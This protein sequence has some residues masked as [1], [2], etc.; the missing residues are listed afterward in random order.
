M[1]YKEFVRGIEIYNEKEWAVISKFIRSTEKES[2]K[3]WQR[4][5]EFTRGGEGYPADMQKIE[6]LEIGIPLNTFDLGYG[7]TLE[8]I[9]DSTADELKET[10]AEALRADQRLLMKVF[11]SKCLVPG[12]SGASRGFWDSFETKA[13]PPYRGN[14]FLTSHDHYN[15]S[16]AATVSLADLTALKKHIREHGYMGDLYLFINSGTVKAF[17][18]LAGWTTAM[19]ATSIIE[20]VATLGLRAVTKFNE[21]IVVIED[22][23]PDGY[24]FG[25]EGQILPVSMREPINPQ[26]RGLK[27]YSGPHTEYPLVEA[28]YRRRCGMDVVHRG[29][30]AVTQITAGSWVDPTFTF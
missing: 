6:A 18:D 25:V 12:A 14:T 7:F 4:S 11:C 22:W 8:A 1:L 27:L 23:V 15:V 5:M 29:A 26:A 20:T 10:Q 2:V 17:E 3:V 9:Q 19:S 21:F 13:P 30:G 24:L 16:G 28:Y